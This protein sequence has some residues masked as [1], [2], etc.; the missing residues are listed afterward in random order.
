[1]S[2]HVNQAQQNLTNSQQE[3]NLRNRI[4]SRKL[5]ISTIIKFF[6]AVM[7]FL[8]LSLQ[9]QYHLD[10]ISIFVL[11][12][13]YHLTDFL[14]ALYY[15]FKMKK[16][17]IR[18]KK[19]KLL[20][21]VGATLFDFFYL[22][23]LLL[24]KKVGY[25]YF[26]YSNVFLVIA[27]LM[28]FYSLYQ[29]R[30]LLESLKMLNQISLL[31]RIYVAI[32]SLFITLKIDKVIIWNWTPTLWGVWVGLICF[33]GISAGSLIVTFS[34]II[35]YLFDRQNLQRSECICSYNNFQQFPTS[36]QLN[37]SYLGV[38]PYHQVLWDIQS[39]QKINQIILTISLCKNISQLL[40]FSSFQF[41]PLYFRIDIYD[42]PVNQQ[43]FSVNIQGNNQ[44]LQQINPTS[45]RTQIPQ[46]V[47]KISKAYFGI[48][49]L[50][51][52]EGG[53]QDSISGSPVLKKSSK[54]HKRAF[55]SQGVA[56]QMFQELDYIVIDKQPPNA[57]NKT[58]SNE[59]K[60]QIDK[61]RC[62]SHLVT[63]AHDDS[64][65][66]KKQEMSMSQTSNICIVCYERGPNA[67]FMNCGHGGTCYQC[68]IDIWKQKTVCYLCRNKI[69]Y[70][71][72][73]DLEDR[74]GDLF[75]VVST[76]QMIDQFNK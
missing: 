70:I 47:Q 29:D 17:Q 62:N 9:I 52:K 63:I 20:G 53:D 32:C 23:C 38:F 24:L 71:L 69:E 6:F 33:I 41:I 18:F 60:F 22:T 50:I 28:N 66:N 44:T 43:Q 68:A 39:I 8:L 10:V 58:T 34:K 4:R 11:F 37:C 55:S 54:G 42:E 15:H 14:N 13:I 56:S 3:T 65:Q 21:Y 45:S 30:A 19:K 7:L 74:Y 26:V 49:S 35:Q 51:K 72:K 27:I 2:T 76:A 48:P 25:Q 61:K 75:K 67:V 12:L 64:I 5:F 1:M 73:V 31:T 40:N 36:G 57:L 59:L 46:V 16:L